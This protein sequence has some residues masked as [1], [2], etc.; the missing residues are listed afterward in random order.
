MF[1][2]L[3]RAVLGRRDDGLIVGIAA[4]GGE[5][6]LPRVGCADQLCDLCA[7]G[8]QMLAAS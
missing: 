4:A 7:A 1:F 6:D 5:H 2:P 3:A 8:Q